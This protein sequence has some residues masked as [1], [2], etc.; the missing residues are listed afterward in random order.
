[1]AERVEFRGRVVLGGF[2]Q[3]VSVRG[4]DAGNPLLLVL[5]GGPGLA[6]MPLF[7]AYNSE[8]EQHFLVAHWDQRGAGRSYDAGIPAESMTLRQFVADAV[9]LIDVLTE[10]FAQKKVYLV[11][12]SW[13]TML[14]AM[15]ASEYPERLHA[16]VGAGQLVSGRRAARTAYEFALRK[17]TEQQHDEAI[18]ALRRMQQSAAD[19]GPTF[20]DALVHRAWVQYFG[21]TVNG[22]QEALFARMDPALLREYFG[23]L[24]QVTQEFS[25]RYLMP[26]TLETDLLHTARRF[27]IPIH[28]FVGRYDQVTPAEQAAEYF[29]AIEAPSKQLHWFENSAHFMPFEEAG[30]FNTLLTTIALEN[31]P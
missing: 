2:G 27:E 18:A 12:H 11:A 7:A 21:G 26:E 13:G 3:E 25:F 1:M 4:D 5:H 28:L 6:E 30:K 10:Q 20:A 16:Y 31:R 24:R 17:A 14:G 8:L 15:I 19:G 29:E 22:S 9:E 23:E